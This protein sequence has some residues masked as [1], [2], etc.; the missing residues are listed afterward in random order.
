MDLAFPV[1]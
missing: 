1:C